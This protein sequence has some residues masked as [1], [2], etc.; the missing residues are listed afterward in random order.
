MCRHTVRP[1]PG[2]GPV[3]AFRLEPRLDDWPPE[4][5]EIRANVHSGLGDVAGLHVGSLRRGSGRG[6]DASRKSGPG[7]HHLGSLVSTS[8]ARN[9]SSGR[10]QSQRVY[11]MSG[12]CKLPLW[13]PQRRPSTAQQTPLHQPRRFWAPM[14]EFVLTSLRAAVGHEVR[15][16]PARGPR[17]QL[18]RFWLSLFRRHSACFRSIW[19]SYSAPPGRR[20]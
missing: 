19:R 4:I 7:M 1:G 2:A 11:R 18:D 8:V 12:S 3:N 9:R 20:A 5:G 16:S 15:H 6:Q 14:R 10:V 13:L 17:H